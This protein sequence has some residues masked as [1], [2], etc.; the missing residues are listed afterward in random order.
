MVVSRSISTHH[1][2]DEYESADDSDLDPDY[3]QSSDDGSSSSDVLTDSEEDNKTR[4][5]ST[6]VTAGKTPKLQTCEVTSIG[7]AS[8]NTQVQRD[9]LIEAQ[10][11]TSSITVAHRQ[12]STVFDKRPHCYYC[13][14][15]QSQVQRHWFSKHGSERK[16]I[17]IGECKDKFIKHGLIAHLR[18]LGNHLHNV[19]VLNKRQGELMVTYRKSSSTEAAN[20]VPCEQCY[21]YVLKRELWRHRCKFGNS[22]TGRKALNAQLMLPAP[23]NVN[24]E[25]Y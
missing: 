2:S 10:Q 22:K 11:P 23:S 5:K 16:V 25:V 24:P 9:Q 3:V 8:T 12:K 17:E 21:A 18:N 6:C 19:E 4:A 14:I 13:G 1:S 7:E 15:Q 20:Y